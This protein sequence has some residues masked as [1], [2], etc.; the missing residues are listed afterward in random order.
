MASSADIRLLAQA[1]IDAM[2]RNDTILTDR[3]VA[4]ILEKP[5]SVVQEMCRDKTITATKLKGQWYISLA[6]L[7]A[8]LFGDR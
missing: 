4:E 8:D 7:N 1:I 3:K 5:L 6:Q 2:P